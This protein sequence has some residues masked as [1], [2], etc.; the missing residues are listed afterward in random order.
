VSL[1]PQTIGL[2]MAPRQNLFPNPTRLPE[3]PSAGT[4]EPGSFSLVRSPLRSFFA[5]PPGHFFQSNLS[6]LGSFPFRDITGAVYQVRENTRSRYV[7]P[8][9]FLNLST[10]CSN[11][12]LWAYCIPQPRLGFLPFRGFSRFAAK[13]DSSPGCAPLPLPIWPL[14]TEAVATTRTDRLRG[15]ARQIGAFFKVGV[16]LPF[17]SLPS[18]DSSSSRRYAS[19]VNSIT[20]AIRSC[21]SNQDLSDRRL[22]AAI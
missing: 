1:E 5:N 2:S 6:D 22:Q 13:P 7:P 20:R 19:T 3:R 8:S 18:S 9:G 11:S 21:C 14:A 17:P 16:N 15:F 12:G 10:A 4:F